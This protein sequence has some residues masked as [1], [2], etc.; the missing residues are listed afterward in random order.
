MVAERF[1]P[2]V[3]TLKQPTRVIPYLEFSQGA[4]VLSSKHLKCALAR[5]DW[6][7]ARFL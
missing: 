4:P 7:K 1:G 3:A 5:T 6:A 2:E